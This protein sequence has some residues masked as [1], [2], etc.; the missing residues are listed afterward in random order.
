M[1]KCLLTMHSDMTQSVIFSWYDKSFQY[2]VMTMRIPKRKFLLWLS[3]VGPGLLVMLA[4]TDAGSL[5]I[6]AQS[7]ALWGY[8]L[9]MQQI[10]LIPVLYIVQELTV[11]LGLVTGKGHGELIKQHFGKTWAWLSVST[12]VIC[13]IGGLLT[14]FSGLAAVGELFGIPIWATMYV[15]VGFLI[16]VG[17]TG[18]YI[19]V[20]RV[21]I[22]LGLFE[23][24]F[25][26][27]AWHAKPTTHEIMSGLFN[28]PWRHP[29]YLYLVAGNI[30]A[31]IMPWM[32]F[33][34]Q[35]A[36][37]DKGLTIKHLK[38]ARW[39]TAIGALVTQ[40]IMSSVLIITAATIGKSN[41]QTPLNNIT[42]ISNALTPILG[43]TTGRILFAF[44]MSGAALVATIVI[45]LTAA[46]GIGEVMGFRRSLEDHPFEAPWFYGIYTAILIGSAILVSSHV[47][48]LVSLSVG[49]E[50]MNT[51]LLPIVLGFLYLL[52]YRIL[53]EPYR[54]KS[55]YGALVAIILFITSGFGM[56]VGF[57]SLFVA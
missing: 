41:P 38:A 54:L 22:F 25:L 33:F 5:I 4:D 39:D 51:M 32:I 3:I 1:K 26:W 14:E 44:G 7:G 13:C 17:W 21:A 37:L 43:D 36:V 9:L 46:W 55:W 49:I 35:S 28:I 30:G 18:S 45:S 24:V 27:V 56:V 53:P 31:V 12:L 2:S 6:S 52:A 16:I 20:E 34:Q 57:L 50:V 15:V 29:S 11:R 47:I 19:S 42:E 40:L 23:I 10:I 48:N 8:R